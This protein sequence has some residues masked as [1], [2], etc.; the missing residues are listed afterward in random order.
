M[1]IVLKVYNEFESRVEY[2]KYRNLS[3]PDRIKI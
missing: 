3:K 1:E 2:L